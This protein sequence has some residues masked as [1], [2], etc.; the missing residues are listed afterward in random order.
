MSESNKNGNESESNGNESN[1][2]KSSKRKKQIIFASILGVL[3]ILIFV[4][5]MMPVS[6]RISYQ[7]QEKYDVPYTTQEAYEVPLY[8]TI[9]HKDPVY[10]TLYTYE[11]TDSGIENKVVS[12]EN[13]YK[14]DKTYTGDDVWGSDE[15]KVVVSF[16]KGLT[17][18]SKPYYEINEIRM[19]DSYQKI[20]GYTTWKEKVIYDYQTKYRDIQ[21]TRQE[22]RSVT[23]YKT[24]HP[25]LY[26][27]ILFPERFT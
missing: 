25:M 1:N 10:K 6:E 3:G 13:V 21:K 4:I 15:Y 2:R 26:E 19:I 14:T 8:K 18:T 11:L 5:L 27:V 24:V 16:Y 7:V 17:S 20:I 12:I 22:T 9:E 23:K